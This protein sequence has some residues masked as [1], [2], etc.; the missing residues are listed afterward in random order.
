MIGRCP[1]CRGQAHSRVPAV[2]QAPRTS[3]AK[4]EAV[5][6]FEQEPADGAAQVANKFWP[7]CSER[8]HLVDLG[9][10]LGE[11]YRIP[12]DP[13]E[14]EVAQAARHASEGAHDGDDDGHA[15]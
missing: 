2:N 5:R 9:M 10:W 12:G 6:R 8:C 14:P 4:H 11:H 15:S 3:G 1:V 7:L 13:T